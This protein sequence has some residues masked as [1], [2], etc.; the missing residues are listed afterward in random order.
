MKKLIFIVP[1][2]F[3]LGACHHP[4]NNN[5]NNDKP[6]QQVQLPDFSEDT[7]YY[8]TKAQFDFG[9]RVNNS[10]AHE[11]CGVYLVAR[12]KQYAD[13]VKVQRASVKAY[14]GTM[15][16]SENIIASFKP[17]NT[18]RIMLCSHWDSRPI[19]DHDPNP[20]D[21]KKPVDGANDG[22]SGVGIL[23]E[24]ARQLSIAKPNIGVDLILFDAEDYGAPE[25]ASQNSEDSWC[26]GSQYWS[27][28][29]HTDGYK[30]RFGILLDM[31]GA[32]DATFFMEGISMYYA[33]DVTKKVWDIANE[34]GFSNY[35]SYT[36][37]GSLTDDHY[38]IN[39]IAKIP[40]VDIIHQVPGSENGFFPYWHT[41]K[42]NMDNISR[43]T[44]K[45]VGQTLMVVIRREGAPA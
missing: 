42:D 25:S 1:M 26:L 24:I 22:A 13:V 37:S 36:P 35:F 29:P 44:L 19:A 16:K 39:K 7:A 5:N 34:L 8:Y 4:V 18:Q 43:K 31:V 30:A 32:E 41:T 17:E 23:I 40:T 10:P 14:N 9:P 15:L 12:L 2:I 27:S 3:V 21:R 11:K 45:I 6:V 38:Y 28:H 20:A 33:P